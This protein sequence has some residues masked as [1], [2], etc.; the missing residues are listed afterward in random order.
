[1]QKFASRIYARS[2]ASK[3]MPMANKT[4]MLDEERELLGQWINKGA[5]LDSDN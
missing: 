2:V 4:G 5:K 1:M 3:A